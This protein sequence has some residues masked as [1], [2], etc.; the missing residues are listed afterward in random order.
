MDATTFARK[1]ECCTA[2]LAAWTASP[3]TFSF[4]TAAGAAQTTVEEL[5]SL[6]TS[7]E[8]IPLFFYEA[9]LELYKEQRDLTEG[10]AS[11]TLAEKLTH[12]ACTLFDIFSSQQEFVHASLYPLVLEG[13]GKEA[14]FG[15]SA[16]LFQRFVEGDE[17]VSSLSKMWTPTFIYEFWAHEFGHVL[18]FWRKD[19]SENKEKTLALVDKLTS[20]VQEL[21]YNT[22]A[23]RGLDLVKFAWQERIV[24]LPFGLD[25]F[26]RK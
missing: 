3:E 14:F 8:Q 21:F 17:R 11:F 18:R 6:F 24:R 16:T 1:W 25:D 4:E 22:A 15:T 12:F 9:A 10:F 26:L 23:D 2:S 5:E 13:E 20:F 19:A 7:P